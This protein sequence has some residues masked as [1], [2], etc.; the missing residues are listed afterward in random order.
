MKRYERQRAILREVQENGSVSLP[1]LVTSLNHS[2][3]TIR[4]D[5][6]ELE[7]EGKVVRTHGGAI[8]PPR[9]ALEPTFSEKKTRAWAEK[10][11]IAGRVLADIPEGVTVFV[12][13]GT[14]CLEAGARLL[15]RG[16][17]PLFTHSIPLLLVGC[18]YPGKI[19]ALGGEVRPVSRAL[20]GGLALDWLKRLHFD[21][22]LLGASA[23]DKCA[24]RT[25]ELQE[26]ALK[27]AAHAHADKCYLLADAEKYHQTAAVEFLKLKDLDRWY[28]DRSLPDALCARLRKQNQ[29][30]VI[31]C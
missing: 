3:A 20:I 5:L 28:V 27:S 17:N 24:A 8:Y 22:V 25:T 18:S 29:L 2:T 15:E 19:T 9:M 31:R 21:Y 11:R 14:T 4:R 16:K 12:D 6:V 23:V 13:A 10:E 30:S 26:A 7:R 1:S